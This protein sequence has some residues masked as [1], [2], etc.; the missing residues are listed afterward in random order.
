LLLAFPFAAVLTAA[1]VP[2][3]YDKRKKE[4]PE[5]PPTLKEVNF[6]AHASILKAFCHPSSALLTSTPY[7][8]VL[9][10]HRWWRGFKRRLDTE[11]VYISNGFVTNGL[12]YNHQA[13]SAEGLLSISA[14]TADIQQWCLQQLAG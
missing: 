2:S 3:V 5:N 14:H 1:I 10:V 4:V 8:Y 6:W 7:A 12:F 9:P 13:P 11:S